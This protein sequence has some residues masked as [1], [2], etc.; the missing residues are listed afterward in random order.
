MKDSAIPN[1]LEMQFPVDIACGSSGGPEYSTDVATMASGYE[2]RNINW[3]QSMM[4][5]NVARGIQNQEQMQ[6]LIEFFRICCGKAISFRFKD[7][8]DYQASKQLIGT[9]DEKYN[10][11]QLV[12]YY[13]AGDMY[14]VR[15]ITKPVPHSVRVY[16]NDVLLK[17]HEFAVSFTNG[18]ITL[19]APPKQDTKIFAD[20]E[21]DVPVRFDVDYLPIANQGSGVYVCS[22]IP[23]IEVKL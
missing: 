10:E 23:L 7:W 21:F 16:L 14:R 6:K 5:F 18:V 19:Q 20:F 8:S 2:Q 1:F 11:F 3:A 12:K 15:V 4:R 9:G 13:I 22:D 17:N